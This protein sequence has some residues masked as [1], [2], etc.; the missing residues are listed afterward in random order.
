ML[1]W[2]MHEDR[3]SSAGSSRIL[4]LWEDDEWIL[5]PERAGHLTDLPRSQSQSPGLE[6][7][8]AEALHRRRVPGVRSLDEVAVVIGQTILPTS[9][10]IQEALVGWVGPKEGWPGSVRVSL[11]RR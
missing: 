7:N 8:A 2:H 11:G 3:A 1:R 10:S 5:N 6:P 9:P 4:I